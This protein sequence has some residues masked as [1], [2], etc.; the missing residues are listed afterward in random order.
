MPARF[1]RFLLDLRDQRLYATVGTQGVEVDQSVFYVVVFN[2][3]SF[4]EVSVHVC[5]V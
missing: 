5:I 3:A 4:D 2:T 1:R